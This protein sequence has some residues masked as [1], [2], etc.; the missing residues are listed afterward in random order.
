MAKSLFRPG[1]LALISG[2]AS[3]VG[4]AFAAHCRRQGMNLA[5]LD[6]NKDTLT[7]AK[8]TLESIS[9]AENT[10]VQTYA[11]DVSDHNAWLAVR[12]S[13]TETFPSN[14]GTID[15]LLLNA[16]T[17]VKSTTAQPWE[18]INYFTKTLNTNLFGVINGLSTLLPL[19]QKS[20][21]PS[22]IILTGS[23]QG[24]TNPPGNPAYNAS[25]SA[26]K[27]LAEQLAYSLRTSGNASFAPHVSVHL[28]VPGW[29]FTGLS[30]NAGPV[31]DDVA[32]EK[33]PK[34]AWLASQVVEF[35]VQKIEEGKFYVLVPDE[36][37]DEQLDQARVTWAAGDVSEGRA[38]L[39]RWEDG[40]KD[41]AAEWIGGEAER[42]RKL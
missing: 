8:S 23:K 37:V 21:G 22:A 6:I 20:R 16:G 15:V 2:S 5:L 19:V 42:R 35:G 18:D 28:L 17:S 11:L 30:G 38:A 25:K 27:T 4:Y 10:K 29:T 40:W 24:I 41:R 13:L 1:A 32:R 34:G 3:G 7:Q 31:S 33:K 26:V 14:E 36:D 9:S 12:D 39:S